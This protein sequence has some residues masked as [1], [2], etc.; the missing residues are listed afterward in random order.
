M[1][2]TLKEAMESNC[3]DFLNGFDSWDDPIHAL[4][5]EFPGIPLEEARRIYRTWKVTK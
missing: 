3:R 5:E 1:N 4:M 2:E